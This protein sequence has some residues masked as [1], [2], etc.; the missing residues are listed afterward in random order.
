MPTTL[1]PSAPYQQA[2][3]FIE[4]INRWDANLKPGERT[5]VT[6]IQHT[7][8]MDRNN[9]TAAVRGNRRC[10]LSYWERLA[11]IVSEVTGKDYEPHEL[12]P[13][14]FDIPRPH[15]HYSV[16]LSGSYVPVRPTGAKSMRVAADGGIVRYTHTDDSPATNTNGFLLPKLP[17][18]LPKSEAP[19]PTFWGD[20]CR[21]QIMWLS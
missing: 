6:R 5:L 7:G 15:S 12:F 2:E 20:G 18:V 19:R 3:H 9:L 4:F 21:L 11:T 16:A 17:I 8:E 10:S 1:N 14:F 13:E